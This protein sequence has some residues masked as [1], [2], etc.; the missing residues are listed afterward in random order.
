LLK[1]QEALQEMDK[2]QA[3]RAYV[4]IAKSTS[5]KRA[6]KLTTNGSDLQ[7]GDV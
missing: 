7:S 5:K 6:K 3:K 2:A 1:L 4:S